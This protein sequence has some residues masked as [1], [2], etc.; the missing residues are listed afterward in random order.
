MVYQENELTQKRI[1]QFWAPLAA[2]WLMMALEGPI[3]TSFIAR[4]ADSTLN[5]AAYGVAHPL[6]MLIESPIIMMLSASIALVKDAESLKKLQRFSLILNACVTAGMALIIVPP[7]FYFLANNIL[8]LP[9]E[10][11][12][13][14]HIA[15]MILL[16]WPAAIGFR[17]FYQ[18]ILI[19]NGY[20]KRV[21]I[22][23]MA[24]L[25]SM[26]LSAFVL[27]TMKVEGVIVGAAGLS[28]GVVFEALWTRYVAQKIIRKVKNTHTDYGATLTRQRIVSFYY[29]LALTSFISMGV[30]PILTFFIG[31]SRMP[32]ESWAVF[33]VVDSF[34]FLFRSFGFAYQEVGMALLGERHKN[35]R[36]LWK[37]GSMIALITTSVLGIIAFS[38]F[39][40]IVLEKL[41][42]LQP[43]LADFALTPMRIL[44]LLPALSV[45]FSM[46]R[47]VIINAHRNTIVT[48][49]TVIEVGII[50]GL[51]AILVWGFHPVGAVAAALSLLTARIA[52]NIYLVKYYKSILAEA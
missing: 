23:T 31:H 33:P 6:A 39:G 45:Y 22:G 43:A 25:F 30:S 24:R 14:A 10:I 44:V 21:A 13:R 7:I 26:L 2:T 38:P 35:H 28:A 12:W 34:V 8:F 27:S 49:S 36:A 42:G 18:G 9:P 17:R 51:M 19:S 16:P 4:L 15:M 20:T 1:L 5:L 41:Y 50:G 32:I 3:L 40:S 11:A 52:A 48:V 46:L 47:S 29:P 37:F